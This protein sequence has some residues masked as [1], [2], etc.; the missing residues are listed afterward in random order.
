MDD[1][2]EV[3][4]LRRWPISVRSVDRCAA[5]RVH[6]CDLVYFAVERALAAL[7]TFAPPVPGVLFRRLRLCPSRPS[8]VGPVG[9]VFEIGRFR[10]SVLRGG[11]V[12]SGSAVGPRRAGRAV[13]AGRAGSGRRSGRPASSDRVSLEV[14]SGRS[15]AWVW[16]GYTPAGSPA[17]NLRVAKRPLQRSPVRCRECSAIGCVVR[18]T[19]TPLGASGRS[20]SGVAA[21]VVDYLEGERQRPGGSLLNGANGGAGSYYA[22]SIE[23]PGRWLGSGAAFRHLVGVVERDSFQ[24][25]LEGRHPTTGERLVTAQGS[26]QRGHLAIGT[27]ARTDEAGSTLYTIRDA[28]RLLGTTRAD[29]EELIGGA[30]DGSDS[31]PND[32]GWIATSLGPDGAVL[33]PD[34]EISRHLDLVARPVDIEALRSDGSPDEELSV[35]EAARALRVSPRYLRRL[36]AAFEDAEPGAGVRALLASR[37]DDVGRFRIRRDDLTEFAA[38][39]RVPVARV[40]FDLTLT[41][42]KSIGVLTMLTTGD[43]QQRF[44][45]A[46][47]TANDTAI[48]YLD[49]HAS[50]TRCRGESIATRGPDRCVV[51]TRHEPG[52]RSPSSSP[53]RRGERRCRRERRSPGPGR[54]SALLPRSGR[55]RAR[56]RPRSAGSYATSVSDG[57]VGATACGR[58]RASTTRCIQEFSQRRAEMDEVRR[59]LEA[60]LGRTISNREEDHVALEHSIRQ[61]GDRP[62]R[63]PEGVA[64]QV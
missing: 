49:K 32:A 35:A 12:R 45:D 17:G 39:R 63:T 38:R 57:G 20:S 36:C 15:C 53:Q 7:S 48:T 1:G 28:A 33:I 40:G 60:R 21:A 14:G 6:R 30:N 2:T 51:P 11:G 41:A 59:A 55:R 4:T 34:D 46:F 42:E 22:D 62:G 10:R 26:S 37:R 24:R 61:A 27:A 52:A 18:L 58:S 31:D 19:V 54:T 43:R 56:Q 5:E 50:I 8:A 47:T 16:R 29:V 9:G 3:W 64:D 44:V 13:R 25:V 23:G